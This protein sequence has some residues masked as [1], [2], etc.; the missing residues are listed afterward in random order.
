MCLNGMDMENFTFFIMLYSYWDICDIFTILGLYATLKNVWT[1][2]KCSSTPFYSILF[3]SILFYSILLYSV[4]LYS[5]LFYSILFYSIL[6]YSTPILF[7]CN[8]SNCCCWTQLTGC[9]DC[10]SIMFT[11]RNYIAELGIVN[12]K[13][14]LKWFIIVS[15][16]SSCQ[17]HLYHI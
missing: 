1:V 6:F 5:I 16:M 10:R 13:I 17:N 8:Q 15:G 3:Y 4:L 14:I 12:G 7:Y 9:T 2:N 11:S